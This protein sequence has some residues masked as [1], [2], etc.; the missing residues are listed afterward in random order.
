[1]EKA[2]TQLA[3]WK[4][5]HDL[6]YRL[7]KNVD[8]ESMECITYEDLTTINAQTA[9]QYKT[10]NVSVTSVYNSGLS[11]SPYHDS[12]AL[13]GT[14]K[15]AT[16]RINPSTIQGI[17]GGVIPFYTF[18]VA[19]TAN[20][21]VTLNI[22]LTVSTTMVGESSDFG[23]NPNINFELY[24]YYGDTWEDSF[25][26]GQGTTMTLACQTQSL[27]VTCY[28]SCS[29]QIPSNAVAGQKYYVG[30]KYYGTGM[31]VGSG[32]L[33]LPGAGAKLR[34]IDI[35]FTEKSGTDKIKT[36]SKDKC[37]PWYAV[38]GTKSNKIST[39]EKSGQQPGPGVFME[40]GIWED[41]TGS[42]NADE[43]TVTYYYKVNGTW[44]SVCIYSA[45]DIGDGS[46]VNTSATK[47]VNMPLNINGTSTSDIE[48]EYIQ[49]FCGEA[50]ARRPWYYRVYE[51]V[52][53]GGTTTTGWQRVSGTSK[54]CTIQLN[55]SKKYADFVRKTQAVHFY[56]KR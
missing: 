43:I 22:P 51:Y 28:L 18:S 46:D 11:L 36:Y 31:K 1:M 41:V 7:P 53:G 5:L 55:R 54:T 27:S 19:A 25:L 47:V 2:T 17:N 29:L 20:S 30:I 3:T 12:P 6:G 48:D 52:D 49:F 24:L 37:V 4:D 21:T 23:A 32:Q 56:I 40:L 13:A 8:V 39:I 15:T 42:T 38:P 9:Y 44:K 33:G 34:Y 35:T 50:G 26:I 16:V 45:Y 14:T 10:N